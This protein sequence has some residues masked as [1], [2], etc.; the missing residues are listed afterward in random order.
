MRKST[1]RNL[2]LSVALIVTLI[3]IAAAVIFLVTENKSSRKSGS[4]GKT[5]SVQSV[6][7]TEAPVEAI[8]EDKTE[9]VVEME[10][11]I[12][13]SDGFKNVIGEK[14]A[15]SSKVI[16]TN[17]TAFTMT[18]LY[19]R[20]SDGPRTDTAWGK[21]LFRGKFSLKDKEQALYY[22]TESDSDAKKQNSYDIRMEID[23]GGNKTMEVIE[24]VRFT[25]TKEIILHLDV[26]G[27][28]GVGYAEYIGTD[29]KRYSTRDSA[30][31]GKAEE[32]ELS[33]TPTP[34]VEEQEQ[35]TPVPTREAEPARE[36]EEDTDIMSD[37]ASTATQYIGQ[38]FGNLESA[39]GSPSS[40]E[41]EDE[42]D[43]GVT[44]YHYYSNFTV[45]TTVDENGNEIV[46][47]IW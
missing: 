24:N 28:Y 22:Y 32:A 12:E 46:T 2:I 5:A 18:G 9:K 23:F 10:P 20:R 8:P 38:S 17:E 16:F 34:A 41:Y 44:G 25:G 30:Q 42:P 3:L 35:A 1:R 33:P 43:T 27:D 4:A 39:L 40:S 29:G 31:A 36:I 21:E 11:S 13:E 14:S 7:P 15:V 6:S 45:S 47:G 19:L 26:S 37:D